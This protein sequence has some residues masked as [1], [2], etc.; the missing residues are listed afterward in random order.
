MMAEW[1]IDEVQH[2]GEEYLD[3][4]QVARYDEKIPFDPSEEFETL[5]ELG[6]SN[7]DMVVDFGTG[8][9]VFPLA[10]SEH[11]DRVVAVDVSESMLN[12]VREKVDDA[13]V[14]NVEIVHDGGV[15]YEHEG[16]PASFFFSKN[17][18]HHL[19][20]F[21]KIEALKTVG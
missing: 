7:E 11:C 16:D 17:A 4:V 14:G 12:V 3:P 21:W 5:L 10:V 13:D 2:A 1:F 6:L 15:S 20:D 9:G 19:P 8:T 18:L